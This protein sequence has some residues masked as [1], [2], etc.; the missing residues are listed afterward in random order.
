MVDL[1]QKIFG[2]YSTFIE[3][4]NMIVPISREFELFLEGKADRLNS[5]QLSLRE[6]DALSESEQRAYCNGWDIEN[7]DMP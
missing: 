2:N 4:M 1:M 5:R 7:A 3:P 6:F